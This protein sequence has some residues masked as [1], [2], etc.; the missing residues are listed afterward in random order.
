MEKR[1]WT[2]AETEIGGKLGLTSRVRQ[3]KYGNMLHREMEGSIAQINDQML[4]LARKQYPDMVAQLER[5]SWKD[6]ILRREADPARL[7]YFQTNPMALTGQYGAAAVRAMAASEFLGYV[8]ERWAKPVK[9]V[10]NELQRGDWMR[11]AAKELDGLALPRP[12]ARMVDEHYKALTN[13]VVT[14]GVLRVYDEAMSYFR[15]ISLMAPSYHVRN[16][17]GGNMMHGFV[18]GGTRD[19]KSYRTGLAL[20]AHYAGEG[21]AGNTGKW[22]RNWADMALSLDKIKLTGR[23]GTVTGRE[24]FKIAKENGWF[25]EGFTGSMVAGSAATTFGTKQ[26]RE[27][28]VLAENI[29]RAAHGVDRILKGDTGYQA[30]RSIGKFFFNY[31]EMGT[32]ER[33]LGRRLVFF[34]GWPRNNFILHAR[35]MLEYPAHDLKTAQM[36]SRAQTS[37]L[38]SP[39]ELTPKWIREQIGVPVKKDASGTSHYFMLSNW[40]PE[41]DIYRMAEMFKQEKA[42]AIPKLFASYIVPPV[43]WAIEQL[44][45]KQMYFDRKIEEFPGE[46]I[47]FWGVPMNKRVA[48]LLSQVRFLNEIDRLNP[49]N[50]FSAQRY[51]MTEISPEMKFPTMLAG[52]AYPV[53]PWKEFQR[54]Q[55]NKKKHLQDLDKAIRGAARE[56]DE[57]LWSKYLKDKTR[58]LDEEMFS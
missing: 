34:Y 49:G 56:G 9:E 48:Y 12:L 14:K 7:E 11:V 8:G 40:I 29:C 15:G 20:A 23:S 22:S 54:T 19:Y 55:W 2:A 33:E 16:V 36:I 10:T 46:S 30:G 13:D 3:V 43:R 44:T 58:F 38:S 18:H 39:E 27:M 50:V 5:R 35:R 24:L 47:A 42:G 28:A 25:G 52:R 53:E 57:K 6:A 4:E 51:G 31:S 32:W 45:N 17:L 26:N 37:P 21:W 1:G 41:A